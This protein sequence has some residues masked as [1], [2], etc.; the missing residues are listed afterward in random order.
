MA[1]IATK[2]HMLLCCNKPETVPSIHVTVHEVVS[3]D[4]DT[5]KSETWKG[6]VGTRK[7]I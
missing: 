3:R 4:T 2:T 1:G 7:T 6:Q 5:A